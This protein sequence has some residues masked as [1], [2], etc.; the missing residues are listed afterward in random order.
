MFYPYSSQN[1]KTKHFLVGKLE[2]EKQSL[3]LFGFRTSLLSVISCVEALNLIHACFGSAYSSLYSYIQSL[4]IERD[5]CALTLFI[6]E[7]RFVKILL[8]PKDITIPY[9]VHMVELKFDIHSILDPIQC[10][11]SSTCIFHSLYCICGI[12]S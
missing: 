2:M 7:R 6:M 5:S 10:L 9:M 1:Y 8:S 12:E 11:L 4:D 3:K